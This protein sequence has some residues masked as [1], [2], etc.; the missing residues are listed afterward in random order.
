MRDGK[1]PQFVLSSEDCEIL[2]ALDVAGSVAAA[3]KVAGKSPSVLSR[4]LQR[5]DGVVPVLE[6]RRGQ[7]CLSTTG[8]EL[9]NWARSASTSQRRILAQRRSLRMASTREFAARILA[10]RLDDFLDSAERVTC[11]LAV[12]EA[13]VEEAL[14]AGRAD[15]GFDCSAPSDPTIRFRRVRREPFAVVA[16]PGF[17][18]KHKVRRAS[19]LLPLPSLEYER[20]PSARL[21]ALAAPPE[22]VF[23]S[24]NDIACVREACVA[25]LGWAVLPAYAVRREIDARSLRAVE[26]WTIRDEAFGVYWLAARRDVEPWVRRAVEWLGRQSL[27]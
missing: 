1:L 16:A 27:A 8:R 19:D 21:L 14:L 23:A 20:A 15:L 26:G 12:H 18:K 4:Q 9:V 11:S 10:G 3:A 25:A 24:F 13:G 2:L 5:I 7:W 22:N 6:K 17:L